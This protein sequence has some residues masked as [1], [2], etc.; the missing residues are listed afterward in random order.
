MGASWSSDR[1]GAGASALAVDVL[2]G[3]IVC[4]H[5]TSVGDCPERVPAMR[6]PDGDPEDV[7]HIG[8]LGACQSKKKK[9]K[10]KKNLW[11]G[12]VHH[13]MGC[14]DRSTPVCGCPQ[15]QHAQQGDG[16]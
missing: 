13:L 16:S 3:G 9:K 8:S 2:G 11:Q 7:G 14:R 5:G 15:L 4:N 6:V 12:L 10:K 1:V